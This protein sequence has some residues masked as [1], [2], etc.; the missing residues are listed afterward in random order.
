[1]PNPGVLAGGVRGSLRSE[2]TPI[3]YVPGVVGLALAGRDTGGSQ[4]FIVQS[5]QPHLTGAYPVLGRVVEQAHIL[6]RVQ[7]GDQLQMWLQ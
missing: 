5:P 6:D 4:F 7:P 1:M 2:E 3:P